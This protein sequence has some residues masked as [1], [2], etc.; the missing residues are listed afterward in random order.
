MYEYCVDQDGTALASVTSY[1]A[2]LGRPF[3]DGDGMYETRK[4][5][6]SYASGLVQWDIVQGATVLIEIREI[7]LHKKYLVPA[8]A[9]ARLGDLTPIE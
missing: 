7:G 2:I 3:D 1:A 5:E 8:Q 4:V 9:E 6:G